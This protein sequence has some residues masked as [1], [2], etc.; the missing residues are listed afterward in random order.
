[1]KELT[2]EQVAQQTRENAIVN[3]V[4]ISSLV[5]VGGLAITALYGLYTYK[6]GQITV[7][8]QALLLNTMMAGSFLSL[9]MGW[10]FY[11]Y[12]IKSVEKRV[13]QSTL[14]DYLAGEKP[15]D[16]QDDRVDSN[17]LFMLNGKAYSQLSPAEKQ[18]VANAIC[19]QVYNAD[20]LLTTADLKKISK[21]KNRQEVRRIL[22]KSNMPLSAKKPQLVRAIG[23]K[24][25]KK[26]MRILT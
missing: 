11:F 25:D 15:K 16:N 10:V 8:N 9:F 23:S 26:P 14:R 20:W 18:A 17:Y 13:G 12:A 3:A 1:M 4:V 21:T 5:S 22:D 19:L 24:N 2:P 6:L 7:N